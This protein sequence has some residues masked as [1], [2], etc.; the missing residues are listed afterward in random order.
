[1]KIKSLPFSLAIL[2]CSCSSYYQIQEVTTGPNLSRADNALVY[3][4]SDCVITYDL[5]SNGGSTDFVFENKT[6]FLVYLNLD[7]SFFIKDGM[8]YDY[9][10]QQKSDKKI[11]GCQGEASRENAVIKIPSHSKK[12]VRGFQITQSIYENCDLNKKPKEGTEPAMTF[13]A[14]ESPITFENR[15]NYETTGQ[16]EKLVTNSFYVSKV[17]N[18]NG[19]DAKTRVSKPQ[20]SNI[21][22]KEKSCF[23]NKSPGSYYLKIDQKGRG[24]RKETKYTHTAG[25]NLYYGDSFI[26]GADYNPGYQ[27]NPY[28]NVGVMASFGYDV[29][30]TG[31]NIRLMPNVKFNVTNT[32]V[33]P[34]VRAGAGPGALL[35]YGKGFYFA[36]LAEFGADIKMNRANALSIGLGLQNMGELDEVYYETNG[37]RVNWSSDMVYSEFT[38]SL[39]VR[40]S[41]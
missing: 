3:E 39:F 5:W 9:N 20:C 26:I 34:F 7:N 31:L 35:N 2:F 17:T 30:D 24:Y 8:A 27:F 40:Y 16:G 21:S 28:F 41:F 22:P 13:N 25:V 29:T 32:K 18:L 14:K 15:I 10:L 23:V 33:S 37:D 12:A 36:Y 1:M 19:N 6:G 11:S 38:P 4:N